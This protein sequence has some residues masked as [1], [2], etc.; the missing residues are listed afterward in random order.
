MFSERVTT[1]LS[2]GDLKLSGQMSLILLFFLLELSSE[3]KEVSQYPPYTCMPSP[4]PKI[5][6]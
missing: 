5:N 6:K 3:D 2:P 4:S 1:G